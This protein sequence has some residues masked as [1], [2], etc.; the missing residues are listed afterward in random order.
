[1]QLSSKTK[2]LIR[3]IFIIPGV[4]YL[5]IKSWFTTKLHPIVYRHYLY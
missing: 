3:A 2:F 5:R 1:M 4:D